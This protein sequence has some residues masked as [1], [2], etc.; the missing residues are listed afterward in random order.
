MNNDKLPLALREAFGNYAFP[1]E[2][3]GAKAIE[4]IL[5][6]LEIIADRDDTEYRQIPISQ[7]QEGR[8]KA[9]SKKFSNIRLNLSKAMSPQY[10]VEVL[11]MIWAG[12]NID[13]V[14]FLFLILQF[15]KW[16]RDLATIQITTLEAQILYKFYEKAASGMVNRE[17]LR[18]DFEVYVQSEIDLETLNNSLQKLEKLGCIILTVDK[19]RL[20]EQII[21]VSEYDKAE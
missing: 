11:S 13:P 8:V 15:L 7:N 18:Q 21:F 10:I 12:I 20:V 19:I 6:C 5:P 4:P 14:S 17:I 9:K 3:Y 16:S 2:E 1:D